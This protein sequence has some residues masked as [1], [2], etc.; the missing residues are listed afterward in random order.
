M[1]ADKQ[2]RSSSS[3]TPS[4]N[5]NTDLP[6]LYKAPITTAQILDFNATLAIY[7]RRECA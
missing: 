3:F 2:N 1:K 7:S 5:A 4:K 6:E